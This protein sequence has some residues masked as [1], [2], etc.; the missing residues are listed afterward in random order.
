VP[1]TPEDGYRVY[2][3]VWLRLAKNIGQCGLPVVL[4]GTAVPDQF[5]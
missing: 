5:D 2:R 3:N 1:A 4:C